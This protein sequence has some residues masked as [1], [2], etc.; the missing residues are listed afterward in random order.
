MLFGLPLRHFGAW[1]MRLQ[2][3]AAGAEALT[4]LNRI[5]GKEEKELWQLLS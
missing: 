3:L 1:K 4:A 2:L 5:D